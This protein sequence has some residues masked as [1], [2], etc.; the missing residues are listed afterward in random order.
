M[1]TVPMGDMGLCHN[2]R[3]EKQ[4]ASRTKKSMRVDGK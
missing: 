2:A 1:N 4:R 3:T